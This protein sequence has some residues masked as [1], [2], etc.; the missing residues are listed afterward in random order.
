MIGKCKLHL[1]FAFGFLF[2][3]C[4]IGFVLGAYI[5]AR[6]ALLPLVKPFFC[7][8]FFFRTRVS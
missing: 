1:N 5:L 4:S 6:Q 8:G 3:F 7:E 2:L